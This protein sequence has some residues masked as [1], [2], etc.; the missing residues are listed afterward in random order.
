MNLGEI[1][2]FCHE[3]EESKVRTRFKG[4]SV[5]ILREWIREMWD[6]KIT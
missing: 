1:F 6:F 2:F 4:V 3:N 5:L